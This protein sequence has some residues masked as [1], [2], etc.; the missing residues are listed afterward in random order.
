MTWLAS[1]C[2]GNATPSSEAND[3][4][5]DSVPLLNTT[6]LQLEKSENA[7]KTNIV[8]YTGQNKQFLFHTLILIN[9]GTSTFCLKPLVSII[10]QFS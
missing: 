5:G 6:F 4:I 7:C 1:N 2:I 10:I 8:N 9:Y 3:D